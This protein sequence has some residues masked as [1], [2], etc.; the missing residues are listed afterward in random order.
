MEKDR[1]WDSNPQSGG[2]IAHLP[3]FANLSVVVAIFLI[4]AVLFTLK[5]ISSEKKA[6]LRKSPRPTSNNF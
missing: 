4:G 3:L 5:G 6:K 2:N 1:G